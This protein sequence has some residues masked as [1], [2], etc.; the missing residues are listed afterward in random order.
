MNELE[1]TFKWKNGV[2]FEVV[3]KSTPAGGP[4]TTYTV[5]KAD[6]NTHMLTF[7]DSLTSIMTTYVQRNMA[8]IRKEMEAP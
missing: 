6:E 3:A 5:I 4:V 7:W 2:S 8:E 1:L